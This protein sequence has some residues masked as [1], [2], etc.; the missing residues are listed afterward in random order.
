MVIT[1]KKLA[2]SSLI[3][4][5]VN[6]RYKGVRT[7]LAMGSKSALPSLFSKMRPMESMMPHQYLIALQN[8]EMEL[9]EMAYP[10]SLLSETVSQIFHSCQDT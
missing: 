9:A 1:L 10:Q 8:H 3:I 4:S 5:V 2:Y 7:K 6:A